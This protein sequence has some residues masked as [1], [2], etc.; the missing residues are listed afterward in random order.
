VKKPRII[1]ALLAVTILL[2]GCVVSS[3][4][5]FYTEKDI[6]FDASLLGRWDL[7]NPQNNLGD[8][9]EFIQFQTLGKSSYFMGMKMSDNETDWFEVHL[10]ELKG[11]KFLDAQAPI[12]NQCFG[13]GFLAEHFVSKVANYTNTLHLAWLREDW[14]EELLEKDP[15]TLRHMVVYD[16]PE[17]TNGRIVLTADTIDLQKF[18][19][20]YE[21]N[22]NAFFDM[23]YVK[24]KE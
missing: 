6:V 19:L 18:I 16:T 4:Y 14:T 24:A 12:T 3:V 7:I 15:Q 22:T 9:N 11:Q 8:T 10:F 13:F 2:A 20:K 5:P 21:A 1:F 23:K 17:D